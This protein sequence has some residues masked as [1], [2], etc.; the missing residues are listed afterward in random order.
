MECKSKACSALKIRERRFRLTKWNV[1]TSEAALYIF[2]EG[3]F[4]LTKWNVNFFTPP[5]LFKFVQSF[6]LTKWN[7]NPSITS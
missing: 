7:V 1:N 5:I 3:G 2:L 6:R 4:R